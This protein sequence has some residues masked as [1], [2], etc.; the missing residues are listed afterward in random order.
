MKVFQRKNKALDVSEQVKA[1]IGG[2]AQL[3]AQLALQEVQ[4]ATLCRQF[5][6]YSQ[7]VKNARASIEYLEVQLERI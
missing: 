3:Q 2:V 4:L 1:T 7:E 5:T 6:D